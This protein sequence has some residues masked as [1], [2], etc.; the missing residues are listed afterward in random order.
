MFLTFLTIFVICKFGCADGQVDDSMLMSV[1]N[2]FMASSVDSNFSELIVLTSNNLQTDD[3]L[4]QQLS[5]F[6]ASQN[7]FKKFLLH[8]SVNLFSFSFFND[9]ELNAT[10]L[11]NFNQNPRS[12]LILV[13]EIFNFLK[14]GTNLINFN[15]FSWMIVLR[16]NID[17]RKEVQIDQIKYQLNNNNNNNNNTNL[18]I[19]SRVY[20]LF[21]CKNSTN[22]FEV[23]RRHDRDDLQILLLAS[24]DSEKLK[25]SERRFIWDRR[26]NL[27]G[28]NIKVAVVPSIPFI[29]KINEVRVYKL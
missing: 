18:K 28:V 3:S 11:T 26:R 16:V 4:Q 1:V 5:I 2:Q 22:I 25:F 13:F 20:V 10:M 8:R 17:T 29:E 9:I 27:T 7:V 19:N 15:T 14:V 12:T 23:Y 24:L 6:T 21:S